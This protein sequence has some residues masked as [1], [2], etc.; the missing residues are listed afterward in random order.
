MQLEKLVANT[1]GR[2]SVVMN[3]IQ[4]TQKRTFSDTDNCGNA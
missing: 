1:G 2:S 3:Q 4:A